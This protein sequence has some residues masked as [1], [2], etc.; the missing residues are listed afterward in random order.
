MIGPMLF[1]ATFAW[2]IGRGARWN[3][4]GAAYLLAGLLLACAAILA[5]RATR[6]RVPA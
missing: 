5:A 1:A 6:S 4:P 2:A 3:V